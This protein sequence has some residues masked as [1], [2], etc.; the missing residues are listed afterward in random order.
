MKKIA[1]IVWIWLLSISQ[2]Q[3]KT[4]YSEYNQWK[5]STEPIIPTDTR[6]VEREIR[7]KW[8]KHAKDQ[9]MYYREDENDPQFPY[10]DKTQYMESEWT[11][12]K[13]GINRI[14]N[15]IIEEKAIYINIKDVQSIQYIHLYNFNSG[16]EPSKLAEFEVFIENR[17]QYP[18][19]MCEQC[20]TSIDYL[21]DN[22]EDT[23]LEIPTNGHVVLNLNAYYNIE[24]ITFKI[25]PVNNQTFTI[26]Y[27]QFSNMENKVFAYQHV[28]LSSQELYELDS[29]NITMYDVE[30][31]AGTN[32]SDTPSEYYNH[33][34]HL[35][36]YKDI[37]YQY[38]SIK[39]EYY[40]DYWKDPI[41]EYIYKDISQ[42]QEHFRF[43]EREKCIIQDIIFTNQ[44]Q[45]I[46]DFIE[47]CSTPYKI[48]SNINIE[49][50]GTYQTDI[51]LPYQTISIPTLVAIYE[52]D[53]SL[54]QYIEKQKEELK[55]NKKII[56][57]LTLKVQNSPIME[58][59]KI[60][61]I[62][63]NNPDVIKELELLKGEKQYLTE[64]TSNQQK[65]I[66]KNLK[67]WQNMKIIYKN[68]E[69]SNYQ[70]DLATWI[71]KIQ[72]SLFTK[73]TLFSLLALFLFILVYR[74]LQYLEK[75]SIQK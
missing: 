37:F 34:A 11:E 36:R 74:V 1:M 25:K 49:Q 4:Y 40:D 44:N 58:V 3:A 75:K 48:E 10:I 46:E 65:E 59:E 68:K 15:R 41:G 67:K 56:E 52:N 33:L 7:Y 18:G 9:I 57:Q 31:K 29:Q 45:S 73:R 61:E 23:Y 70:N 50:N 62:T 14:K 54:K 71:L 53:Q 38:Y 27:G 17:R 64:L 47:Y 55:Q 21:D 66:E 12:W 63:K 60:I 8:Y 39:K 20:T 5:H 6:V 2:V 24:N 19:G 51:K 32:Y 35:Y 42:Y 69:N 30:L 43:K 13:T 26:A 28:D 16:N 72:G 22:K